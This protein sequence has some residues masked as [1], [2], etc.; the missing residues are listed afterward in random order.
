MS[1]FVNIFS[2]LTKNK[3]LGICPRFLFAY[4]LAEPPNLLIENN[5]D[6]VDKPY[7][8][9]TEE[10]NDGSN[11]SYVVLSIN[12]LDKSVNGPYNVEYGYTKNE[13]SNPRKIV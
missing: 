1:K 7:E 8:R 9:S 13:F 6:K 10:Q 11:N 12:A 3:N 5:A 4:V 2:M